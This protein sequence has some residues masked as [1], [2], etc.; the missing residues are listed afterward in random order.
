M[1]RFARLAV[2]A[3]VATYV[4]IVAGGLVRATDSGLG[5][6]DWPLCF[7]E[8]VP[9]AD[10]HAW[11]E[12]THRLIAAVFVGPL[13]GAVGL[14]TLFSARRRDRPL[15]AA[16]VVAGVLVVVQSLI[17]ALV[18]LQGLAAELV[19]IHLGMALTVLAATLFI[20]ERAHHG[21]MPAAHA[22]P[23]MTRLVAATAALVFVQMLLGSWVTGHH[24]G[25]AYPDFPL[26]NG[27]V[28]PS[29]A[30]PGQAAQ[31]AHRVMSLVV[32]AA[33]VLTWL[34]V[35]R[36]TDAPLPRGLA[37]W[38]LIGMAAQ[39]ALGGLN[40]FSRLSAFFVVPHLALGAALWAWSFW[41]VLAGRRLG[42]VQ[43]STTVPAAP[44]DP[45]DAVRAR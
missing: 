2:A 19:T 18:V 45:L 17:G 37:T 43:E 8:W 42:A 32:A 30:G 21:P 38:L 40:V 12:H 11:I 24:G 33:V 25:L 1:T 6:P 7:G 28:L 31:F 9:P 26:M 41:L 4:L 29:I 27:T 10:L 15:L 36:T 13:V 20:A 39:I 14:I 35:R 22:R 5:C 16:A 23:A 44:D 3:A 34:G